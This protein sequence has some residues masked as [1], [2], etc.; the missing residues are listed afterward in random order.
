MGGEVVC[1]EADELDVSR[2]EF[3]LEFGKGAEFGGAD[4]SE[5]SWV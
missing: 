1:G 4:G 5:I 2:L 3:G